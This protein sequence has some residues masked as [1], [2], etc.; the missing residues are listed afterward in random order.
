VNPVFDGLLTVV[1]PNGLAAAL[2]DE[3]TAV[4]KFSVYSVD[5]SRWCLRL[6]L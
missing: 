5:K 4:L 1:V 6:L 3:V 2:A